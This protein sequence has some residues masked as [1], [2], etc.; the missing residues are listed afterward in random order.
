MHT[1]PYRNSGVAYS[2]VI[3]LK[4]GCARRLIVLRAWLL[5]CRVC[6]VSTA[7]ADFRVVC[8]ATLCS[9]VFQTFVC[10]TVLLLCCCVWE[11]SRLCA[12]CFSVTVVLCEWLLSVFASESAL[13]ELPCC[14][15]GVGGA[16]QTASTESADA[17]ARAPP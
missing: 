17:A 15:H 12:D 14:V 4:K 11:I 8:M 16:P 13:Q 7:C 10:R 5:C 3:D 9:A 1:R 2:V 6:S